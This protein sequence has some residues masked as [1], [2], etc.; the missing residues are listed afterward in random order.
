[1]NRIHY[2]VLSIISCAI[3]G[4]LNPIANVSA[5]IAYVDDF[6]QYPSPI[7]VN[8]ASYINGYDI[9]FA[10]A[11][12]PQD[13]KVIFGFVYSTVTVCSVRWMAMAAQSRIIRTK[14]GASRVM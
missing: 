11:S 8:N 6:D 10:A 7:V 2:P 9:R 3:F 4:F 1:M 5:Q 13:F 14:S 12:G